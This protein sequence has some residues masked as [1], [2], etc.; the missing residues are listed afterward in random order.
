[1]S[2]STRHVAVE[3]VARGVATVVVE[4]VAAR[5]SVPREA[6]TRM[7]VGYADL[8]GT[9]GG[10]HLEWRAIAAARRMLD[11]ATF[12]PDEERFALGASLGQC[13]GGGVTIRYR[14]LDAAVLAAWIPDDVPTIQ[15][16]GAGHVGRALVHVLALLDV[17]IEWIDE[18]ESAF[19]AEPS[20]ANVRRVCV[21]AV[22]AEVDVAPSGCFHLVLTHQHDL[23]LRIVEAILRRGEFAWLG[24]IGS[25]TKRRRFA[26]LL[27]ERGISRAML[28]RI[29]CPIGV[30]TIAGKEPAHIAIAVAAQLVPLIE[31]ARVAISGAKAA[32]G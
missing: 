22:E 20:P 13:C 28:D 9:I 23:D 26:H 30:E 16:H 5:G 10:G 32:A 25:Q 7:L 18:R 14:V 31:Q 2:T 6:G 21:D 11:D 19:P 3:R 17:A 27:T 24:L 12:R 8:V 1:M 15:I 4:V 29:C